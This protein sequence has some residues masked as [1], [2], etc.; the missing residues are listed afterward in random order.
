MTVWVG[1]GIVA[2]V[3]VAVEAGARWMI[4]RGR[5][6]V[7]VPGSR[8]RFRPDPEC[9]PHLE[10]RVRFDVN[11]QGE[12]GGPVPAGGGGA[13]RV[14]VVGGSAAECFLLDQESC[15][16]GVLERELADPVRRARLGAQR[17]HVGNIGRSSVDSHTL[18]IILEKVLPSYAGLDAIVVMVGASDVL[19]WLEAGA[20]PDRP[21]TTLS[22]GAAFAQ[23]PEVVLGWRPSRW[24]LAEVWRRLRERLPPRFEPAG[25]RWIARARAMRRDAK[26]VRRE[27]PEAGVV[28]RSF[29]EH[30][31]EVLRL[32][33]RAAP[34]VVV[35]RQ[36]WFEK[37]RFTAEEE[38]MFWNGGVGQAFREQVTVYYASEVIFALM[39]GV[40]ARAARL[41]EA[42]GVP[43]VDLRPVLEMNVRFFY[44][45]FHLTPVG[46]AP[47]GR[48][49]ADVVTR[50][51]GDH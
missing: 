4:R 12:R 9:Y 33:R 25:G 42:Q 26:E 41:A 37:E 2:A 44:D 31:A 43:Q 46:C 34:R 8:R 47:V 24:G 48:L 51:P 29:E 16:P 32:C 1:L 6:Y 20:P 18:R 21:A 38:A 50:G 15:W 49:L 45:H 28:Y 23:H 19:R 22:V 35:A 11:A 27:V 7:W 10:P 14:L 5:Y 40:D 36:P 3:L 13:F 39:A 30:F 17:V